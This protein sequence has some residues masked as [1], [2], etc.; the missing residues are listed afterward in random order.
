[1]L[2]NFPRNPERG[3]IY[4]RLGGF[5]VAGISGVGDPPPRMSSSSLS[6]RSGTIFLLM[7]FV[8][9]DIGSILI[10]HAVIKHNV[11]LVSAE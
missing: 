9:V 5:P 8:L 3:V 2:V 4:Q 1:M 10:S 11:W 7:H 6:N